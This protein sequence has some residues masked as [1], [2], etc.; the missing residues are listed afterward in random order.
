[1]PTKREM[2]VAPTPVGAYVCYDCGGSSMG[3]H[4]WGHIGLSVGDGRVIQCGPICASMIVTAPWKRC[5]RQV[6]RAQDT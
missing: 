4:D 1:M 3:W 6:G 5:Q 2:M